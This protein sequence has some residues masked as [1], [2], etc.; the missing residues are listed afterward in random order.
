M[1]FVHSVDD[2]STSIVRDSLTE[3]LTQR[4]SKR[5]LLNEV[6]SV[7]QLKLLI[8]YTYADMGQ[9]LCKII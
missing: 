4:S 6:N 9:N 1:D 7:S 8:S 5:T 3:P 2:S